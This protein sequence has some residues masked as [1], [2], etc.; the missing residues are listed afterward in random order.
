M[1][2]VAMYLLAVLFALYVFSALS[3]KQ[4]TYSPP[5]DESVL[6]VPPA[7]HVVMPVVLT[8]VDDQDAGF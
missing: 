7:A 4:T 8:H 3:T 1:K 5:F 2:I 6:A